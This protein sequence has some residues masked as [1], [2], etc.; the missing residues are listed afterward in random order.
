VRVLTLNLWGRG[1]DWPSRRRVLRDGLRELSPDL[2]AFQ[3][4]FKLGDEDSV[5]EI[6]GADYHVHH[7]ATGLLGDGNCAA[8]A[9]RWRWSAGAAVARPRS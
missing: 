3:E 8:V 2:I 1:G 7:Q 4:A 6:L 5:A 9:S